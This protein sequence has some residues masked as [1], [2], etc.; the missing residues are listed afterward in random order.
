MSRGDDKPFHSIS[1]VGLC[2]KSTSLKDKLELDIFTSNI[3]QRNLGNCSLEIQ[4]KEINTSHIRSYLAKASTIKQS[5]ASPSDLR[6]FP[7]LYSSKIENPRM[8]LRPRKEDENP[9][10]QIKKK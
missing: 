7:N 4:E 9:S 10:N 5:G 3:L 6:L 1:P 8:F 2:E